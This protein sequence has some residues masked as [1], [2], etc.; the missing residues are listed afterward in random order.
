VGVCVSAV[1]VRC[2]CVC[3][4]VSLSGWTNLRFRV[5]VFGLGE[6]RVFGRSQVEM[7][8]SVALLSTGLVDKGERMDA[9]ESAEADPTRGKGVGD[10]DVPDD[11]NEELP[12]ESSSRHRLKDLSA[13]TLLTAERA[14]IFEVRLRQSQVLRLAGNDAF[15]DG[16]FDDAIKFYERALYHADFEGATMSFQYTQEHRLQI[17]STLYPV[18][19][20]IAR[21]AL[22]QNRHRDTIASCNK[23][24]NIVEKEYM[25][26][27]ALGKIHFLKGKAYVLLG[28]YEQAEQ[29]LSAS[30]KYTPDDKAVPALLRECKQLRQQHNKNFKSTWKGAFDTKTSI[31][32]EKPDIEPP[33]KRHPLQ[34]Y[35]E[36]NSYIIIAIGIMFLSMLSLLILT[37]Y[38]K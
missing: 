23:C 38:G 22:Q 3:V 5:F 29:E 14:G 8:I 30:A 15:K 4:C 27:S 19:L 9:S 18:H 37:E 35:V 36:D 10:P 32:S 26:D 34:Q 16:Q 20:N 12:G 13:E 7:R 1:C 11:M 24:F 21:C 2:V 25:P 28:E 6:Y 33:D 17:F 31:Y